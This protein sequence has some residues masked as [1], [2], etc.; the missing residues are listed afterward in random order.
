MSAISRSMSAI[1]T[2]KVEVNGDIAD[3]ENQV[4]VNQC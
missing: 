2:G 3:R 4:E 1:L